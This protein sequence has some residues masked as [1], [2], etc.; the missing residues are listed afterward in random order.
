MNRRSLL[1]GAACSSLTVVGCLSVAGQD[2]ESTPEPPSDPDDP[3]ARAVLGSQSERPPHRVRLWNDADDRVSVGLEIE[4][5][6]GNVT[7]DGAYDLD[8]DAHVVV[9][10]HD[11]N[12]YGVT[13]TVD[14][15]TAASI[16]LEPSS[17]D[18]PCPETNLFVLEEGEVEATMEPE[19]DHCE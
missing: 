10:L 15:T 2:D 18:E 6:S 1:A 19:A 16:D 8:T 17:F 14:E 12:R 3:I 5:E 13:V 4:S 11:R 9:L 7:F